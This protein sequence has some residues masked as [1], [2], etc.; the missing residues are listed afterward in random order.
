VLEV[1]EGRAVV[2]GAICSVISLE[3]IER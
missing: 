2:G 3:G 1:K